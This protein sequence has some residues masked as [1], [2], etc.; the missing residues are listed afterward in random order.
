VKKHFDGPG[1]VGFIAALCAILVMAFFLSVLFPKPAGA[2]EI[3]DDV[4]M[5]RSTLIEL[6]SKYLEAVNDREV[7]LDALKDAQ[8]T[9]DRLKS[10]TNCS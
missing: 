4:T 8:K 5:K 1:M 10:A 6:G 7:L 3:D 9:I 2:S